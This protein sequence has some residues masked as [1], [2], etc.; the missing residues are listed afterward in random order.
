MVTVP[1]WQ[2]SI[3]RT[4]HPTA[5]PAS[6]PGGASRDARTKGSDTSGHRRCHLSP[7]GKGPGSGDATF[8]HKTPKPARGSHSPGVM[9]HQPCATS[10]P[11]R[12]DTAVPSSP[13][14]Q[15]PGSRPSAVAQLGWEPPRDL[16]VPPHVPSGFEGQQE[17]AGAAVAMGPVAA[18]AAGPVAVPSPQAAARI[19]AQEAAVPSPRRGPPSATKY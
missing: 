4:R 16:P 3:P 18:V 19:P 5:G 14:A 7:R 15:A 12:P 10:C 1:P 11:H 17:V 9:C 8:P 13:V 6:A 2:G